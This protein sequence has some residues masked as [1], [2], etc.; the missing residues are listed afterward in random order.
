MK[1]NWSSWIIIVKISII[2]QKHT[3]I[4]VALSFKQGIIFIDGRSIKI[5]NPLYLH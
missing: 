5:R 1:G 2:V 3:G 4:K